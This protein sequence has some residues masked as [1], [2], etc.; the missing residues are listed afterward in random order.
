MPAY[1]ELFQ[2]SLLL[3]AV[4]LAHVKIA[5]PSLPSGPTTTAKVTHAEKFEFEDSDGKLTAQ[6][7]DLVLFFLPDGLFCD[8][9]FLDQKRPVLSLFKKSEVYARPSIPTD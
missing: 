3:R 2:V 6:G 4:F 1:S 8:R 7:K 5:M 9:S